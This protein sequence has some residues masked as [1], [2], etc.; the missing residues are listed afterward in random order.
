[1]CHG[2]FGCGLFLPYF[3]VD[4]HGERVRLHF[5]ARHCTVQRHVRLADRADVADRDESAIDRRYLSRD[6]GSGEPIPTIQRFERGVRIYDP[7]HLVDT[8]VAGF[9]SGGIYPAHIDIDPGRF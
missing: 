8:P 1:M 3:A 6:L 2:Q 5:D 4:A 7:K 9:D